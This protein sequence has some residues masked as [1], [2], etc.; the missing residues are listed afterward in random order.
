MRRIVQNILDDQVIAARLAILATYGGNVAAAARELGIARSTLRDTVDASKRSMLH[1][2]EPKVPGR[3]ELTVDNGCVLIGSDAH[4]WPDVV[5]TAHRAFLWAAKT[6]KPK[7]VIVNGDLLD[8]A[9]VSRHPPIG[10]ESRPTLAQEIETVQTRLAEIEK[11]TKN[12]KRIWP[13]GNHDARL[14]TRIAS[15]VPEF[16]RVKGVH[17]SDHFPGWEKCWSV[18]IN[19]SVVVKH[20]AKGG[21]HATHNNTVSGGLTMI[22]GHTHSLKI[23]P[24]TDYR[25]AVRWGVDCGTLADPFGPQFQYI[26]DGFRN[27]RSGFVVLTFRDGKLMWPELVYVVEDGVVGFRGNLITV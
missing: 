16:A 10:W 26:E 25:D 24:Y 21:V 17:L 7:V 19:N 27:W 23:T 15:M 22:T 9:T 4:Y 2:A 8:G 20:R 6:I 11:A 1:P 14:E 3:L 18:W 13:L 5:T 12:A